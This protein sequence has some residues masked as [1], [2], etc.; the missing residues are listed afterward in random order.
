MNVFVYTE[1]IA[2]LA[3]KAAEG[4]QKQ[5]KLSGPS[6][7]AGGKGN[8]K[9]RTGRDSGAGVGKESDEADAMEAEMG[10]AASADADHEMVGAC[11]LNI[12]FGVLQLGTSTS[13]AYR[14]I[15]L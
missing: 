15:L 8:A 1:K 14:F 2:A 9:G 6:A 10:L 13:Y 3:K 4:Q 11:Y 5:A 7:T 12:L